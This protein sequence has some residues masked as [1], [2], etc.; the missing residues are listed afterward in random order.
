MAV[1]ALVACELAELALAIVPA[2]SVERPALVRLVTGRL[3]VV[4]ALAASAATLAL[5]AAAVPAHHGFAS[6]L[7]GVAAAAALFLLVGVIGGKQPRAH[8]G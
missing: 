3:L 1:V 6:G 5:L 2:A 4:A 8:D 7:V